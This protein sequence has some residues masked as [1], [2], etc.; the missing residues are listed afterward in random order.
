VGV[1]KVAAAIL[2]EA[3]SDGE[4]AFL[5]GELALE[6]SQVQPKTEPGFLAKKKI[7]EAIGVIVADF[8]KQAAPLLIATETGL[9]NYVRSALKKART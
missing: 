4:K 7:Q 8:E 5:L 1:T 3:G 9:Q 2:K 6:L